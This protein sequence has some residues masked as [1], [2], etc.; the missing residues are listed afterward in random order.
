MDDLPEQVVWDILGRIKSTVD[1]NSVSLTCK[2]FHELANEQQKSIRF[3]RG[4]GPSHPALISLCNRFQNLEKVEISY[5]G[6]L[7]ELHLKDKEIHILSTSC[8]R[9]KH[10]ILS[11]CYYITDYGL[12]YL[13]SCS[14]LS[15]LK[16]I[17]ASRI[18]SSGILSVLMGCNNLKS[19][20]LINCRHVII[21]NEWMEH[22]GKL[23]DLC[24]K[25]LE[26]VILLKLRVL[27]GN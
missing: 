12:S 15:S 24:I 3:V 7:L 16:L 10:V 21:P 19:L 27:C 1:R 2:R 8:P 22:L 14:N 26:K 5:L 20:H 6:P 13:A 23:E 11:Y 4:L 9:L 17:S 18:T 25:Q